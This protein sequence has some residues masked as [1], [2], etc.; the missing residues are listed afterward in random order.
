MGGVY[1]FTDSLRQTLR[2]TAFLDPAFV[3]GPF[4]AYAADQYNTPKQTS[5]NQAVFGDVRYAFLDGWTL[6]LGARYT[7]ETKSIHGMAF[8]NFPGFDTG[9]FQTIGGPGQPNSY[10]TN[11][12][13]APTGRVAVEWKPGTDVMT[14]LSWSH[15]FKSGGYNGMAMND[16]SELGPYDQERGNTFELGAKTTWLDGKLS[17]NA[18]LFLNKIRNL[19]VLDTV[20]QGGIAFFYV[21]NAANG[22]SKG[23]EF[24]LRAQPTER[25]YASLGVGLLNTKYDKYILPAGTDYTGEEFINSPKFSADAAIQYSIPMFGGVLAP[26]VNLSYKTHVWT[27]DAH[28]PGLDEIAGYGLIDAT[29]P[30]TS[31]SKSWEFA[32]WGRNLGNKRYYL[33]TVGNYATVSG[34]AV[35]YHATPRTYGVRVSYAF[36]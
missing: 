32:I 13:S 25:W 18:A 19:Q 10:I 33:Q 5:H 36:K 23:A 16:V 21:R 14:Y 27:H 17:A 7:R 28:R 34:A 12:W 9:W 15:G 24:E 35:S 31:G 3:G 30:W 1:Y 20:V 26:L 8:A 4:A 2:A 22:T 11:T 6:D 29:I